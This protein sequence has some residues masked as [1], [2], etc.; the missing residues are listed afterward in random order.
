MCDTAAWLDKG[1]LRKIGNAKPVV[2]AYER[3][4]GSAS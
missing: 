1:K 2:T 3:S 4:F